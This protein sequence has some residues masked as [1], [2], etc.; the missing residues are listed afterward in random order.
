MTR[1]QKIQ[2]ARELREAGFTYQDIAEEFGVSKSC[3]Q[4][5][6]K[7]EWAKARD[8]KQN[9][10][11]GPQKR[12]WEDKQ[13]AICPN[14]GEEMGA[15]STRPCRRRKVCR[16]C[17]EYEGRS[18]TVRFIGLRKQ[19]LNNSRIAAAEDCSAWAVANVLSKAHRY[20]LTVPRSPYFERGKKGAK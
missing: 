13:R 17:F 4:R 5:W 14:C 7:P 9:A 8:R 11:R 19:G 18:R 10:K 12:A 15:G 3:A 1:E 16:A 2:R 6:C 20:G